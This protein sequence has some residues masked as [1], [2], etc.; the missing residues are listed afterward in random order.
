MSPKKSAVLIYLMSVVLLRETQINLS[1]QTA[2]G[3]LP[4]SSSNNKS[5]RCRGSEN[6]EQFYYEAYYSLY[7]PNDKEVY[8]KVSILENN[9]KENAQNSA[10][11]AIMNAMTMNQNKYKSY[12]S[13]QFKRG[14][15]NYLFCLQGEPF[16]SNLASLFYKNADQKANTPRAAMMVGISVAQWM[17]AAKVSNMVYKNLKFESIEVMGGDVAKPKTLDMLVAPGSVQT[18]REVDSF[19]DPRIEENKSFQIDY[20]TSVW[21]F[22]II[23][24]KLYTGTFPFKLASGSTLSDIK[25]AGVVKFSFKPERSVA[26]LILKCL[27]AD[28]DQRINIDDLVTEIKTYLN[29]DNDVIV[30]NTEFKANENFN[31]TTWEVEST[32]ANPTEKQQYQTKFG[33]IRRV[34][35][36]SPAESQQ[37]SSESSEGNE[38]LVVLV[39]V[40]SALLMFLV[41]WSIAS[42]VDRFRHSDILAKSSDLNGSNTI[43]QCL[44]SG[45]GIAREAMA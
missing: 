7:D 15:S 26:A 9:E 39:C 20:A 2:V 36:D 32:T 42:W 22:G 31:P 21:E 10:Y 13:V 40:G 11:V 5:F 17:K 14:S 34:L 41:F 1:C 37:V 30:K 27:K 16:Y 45:L 8:A 44:D 19:T 3:L 35:T 12:G 18:Y 29:S 23:L 43:G 33:R 4:K 25:K 24:Y 38:Q 28:P 6:R